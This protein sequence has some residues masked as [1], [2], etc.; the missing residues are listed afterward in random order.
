MSPLPAAASDEHWGCLLSPRG[1]GSVDQI[2]KRDSRMGVIFTSGLH[3]INPLT[4]IGESFGN[5]VFVIKF[6]DILAILYFVSDTAE[7]K[8]SKRN[9][10][11]SRSPESHN[12][13]VQVT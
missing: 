11:V 13:G 3:I 8:C 9:R 12:H 6:A 10:M 1:D 5:R 2:K 4:L 7:A